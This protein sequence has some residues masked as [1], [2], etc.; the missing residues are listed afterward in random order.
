MAGDVRNTDFRQVVTAAAD[1]CRAALEAE[2]YIKQWYLERFFKLQT[3]AF[4]NPESYFHRYADYEED[5]SRD[6]GYRRRE[7]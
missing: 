4:A 2:K 5:N 1:G 7:N 3:T 6:Y